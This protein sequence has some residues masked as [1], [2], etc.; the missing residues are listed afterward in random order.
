VEGGW[1]LT[2]RLLQ[3]L[4]AR[5]QPRG[6]PLVVLLIP[7]ALQIDPSLQRVLV[8][9]ADPRPP[10]QAFLRDPQRPQRMLTDFCHVEAMTC[11]D[12]LPALLRNARQGQ[13]PYYPIDGHWTPAAHAH[14][15]AAVLE[16]LDAAGGSGR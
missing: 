6:A 12:V 13:R 11:V 14:A 1:P 5:L 9:L 8:S 15:A 3:E 10:I 2:R 16:R 7:S 4:R